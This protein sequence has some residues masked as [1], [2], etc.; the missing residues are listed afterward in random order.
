MLQLWILDRHLDNI[1]YSEVQT[2]LVAA[3]TET[4]ARAAAFK[5]FRSE[6]DCSAF[7][8]ADESTAQLVGNAGEGIEPGVHMYKR[9][10]S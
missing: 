2:V 7:M 9:S 6:N 8:F 10:P 3:E 5:E 1:G 4:E